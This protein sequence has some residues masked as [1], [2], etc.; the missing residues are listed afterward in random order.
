VKARPILLHVHPGASSFVVKDRRLLSA[1]FDV[2]GM[3]FI[4]RH[5]WQVPLLMLSQA[6]RLL[7]SRWKV[8]VV[9]FGG[10]HALFPALIARLMGRS[11]VIIAGGTDCVAF[12]SIG[13]GNFARQPLAWVTRRAYA[14][15]HR[16]VP[17]HDSLV[18][19]TNSF[20][21]N[22][23]TEQGILAHIPG[24]RTPI[25][26]VHNGYDA[27]AWP[28]GTMPRDIDVITVASGD[29]RP[30]TI[31]I[32]GID[33]L[34]DAAR[35]RPHLR[36]AIIGLDKGAIPGAP[37]NVVFLPPIPNA[38]LAGQYQRAKIY[39][40]LSL[41]EG[42]P[43][44]LCE[45]MLCGCLPMVSAVG[46]MPDITGESGAIVHERTLDAVLRALDG[47]IARADADGAMRARERVAGRY[48]E[49]RRAR[50]LIGIITATLR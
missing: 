17:V 26:V 31:A 24:L 22:D 23:P 19:G 42:F 14:L 36:F 5:K 43:N 44:A 6:V 4:W 32:K 21:R 18:R 30:A 9:Q 16:I 10:Y 40:Q 34:L 48:T 2:R 29:R 27:D 41:S 47:L 12:P 46:A 33:L 25:P 39:A 13:Y 45:A 37:E 35:A 38:S 28:I 15:A 3:P 20:Q 7:F 11:C 1:A 50:E 8:V 49:E